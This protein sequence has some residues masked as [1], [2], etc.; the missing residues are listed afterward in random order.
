MPDN[1]ISVDILQMCPEN[2]IP[3][4]ACRY[5][6]QYC[7]ADNISNFLR[8]TEMQ[9]ISIM[10]NEYS[11]VTP[12]DLKPEEVESW[13]RSYKLIRMAFEDSPNSSEASV[14]F[15]Y[16]LPYKKF[17]KKE[18]FCSQVGCRADIII[19]TKNIITI[20]EV[21][22]LTMED[23]LEAHF[24]NQAQKY[25]RKLQQFHMA[26]QDSK[27]KVML[28]CLQENELSVRKQQTWFLSADGFR[29]IVHSRSIGIRPLEDTDSWIESDWI[30]RK[31]L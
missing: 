16:V 17:G 7:Y 26:S 8:M 15:E 27:I 14:I 18:Y 29:E 20:V 10:K 23:V 19:L 3:H 12:Y 30:W 9:F 22:D 2:I 31:R 6:G 25:K 28:V 24:H 21:K 13:K 5:L 4:D 1:S 11:R